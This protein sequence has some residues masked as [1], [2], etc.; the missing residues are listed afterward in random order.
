MRSLGEAVDTTA[1]L[2]VVHIVLVTGT[3]LAAVVAVH[4]EVAVV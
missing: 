1:G 3:D 2:V 4:T